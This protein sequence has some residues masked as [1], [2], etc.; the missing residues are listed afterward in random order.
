MLKLR[1]GVAP[2]AQ[3]GAYTDSEKS[4]RGTDYVILRR[5]RRIWPP[6]GRSL[7]FAAQIVHSAA[8]RSG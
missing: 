6:K 3:N 8:L 5:S 7:F 1:L 2:K 4:V